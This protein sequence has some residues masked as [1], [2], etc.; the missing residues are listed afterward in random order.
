MHARPG[1]KTESAWSMGLQE[2][3]PT[4]PYLEDQSNLW[5]RRLFL[6]ISASFD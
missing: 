3:F 4:Q 5:N 2:F 6:T 1:A